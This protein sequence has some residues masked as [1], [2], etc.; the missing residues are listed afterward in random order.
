MSSARYL[1][2][3]ILDTVDTVVDFGVQNIERPWWLVVVMLLF[4][5]CPG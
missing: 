5:V 3:D 4:F 2:F 1:A